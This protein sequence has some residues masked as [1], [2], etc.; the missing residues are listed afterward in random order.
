MCRWMGSHFQNWT[1]YNGVTFLV[2]LLTEWGRTFWDFLDKKIPVGWNLKIG[3]LAVKKNGRLRVVSSFPPR[4]IVENRASRDERARE[5][6]GEDKRARGGRALFLSSPH[7]LRA[8][9]SL[10]ARF[11][12]ISLEE[13]R[14]L[15]AV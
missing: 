1:D 4:N 2:E 5:K 10:D 15:L 6:W 8:L 3:R 14:R 9:S 12:T 11:S 7:F 13:K